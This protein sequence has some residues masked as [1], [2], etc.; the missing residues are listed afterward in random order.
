MTAR[1]IVD[2][3]LQQVIERLRDW[4][5]PAWLVGGTVRDDVLGR[6][7][8]DIDLVVPNGGLR[9]ARALADAL[10]A[11]YFPLDS[12][13]D[14]GRVVVRLA[15]GDSFVID[16]ARLR[17]P[18]LEAD[19]L[20]RD[21]SLNAMAQDVHDPELAIIDPVGGMA[22]LL[23]R[24]LRVA[25]ER[26]FVDD[27][28]RIVRGVRFAHQLQLTWEPASAT[29]AR[30]A[31]PTLHTVA[32]ER[33]R[34][35]LARLMGTATASQGLRAL[36]Q[37]DALVVLL[38]E[39]KALQGVT[40][41]PPH[42]Y[43][44]YDHTLRAVDWMHTLLSYVTARSD[45]V[46]VEAT[47]ADDEL[48]AAARSGFD[49][50]LVPYAADLVDYLEMPAE[51][52][53]QRRDLL[54]WAALLHDVGKPST[55]RTLPDGSI[56][57]EGHEATGASLAR[58]VMA[59]LRFSSEAVQRVTR[60]CAHHSRP[61]ALAQA[62]TGT[63]A[64]RDVYRYFQATHPTGV[65]TALLSLADHLAAWGPNLRAERYLRRVRLA[66]HL[67]DAYFRQYGELVA[68]MPLLDGTFLQ[69]TLG[70]QPGPL[71]G[72][73]LAALREEQAAGTVTTPEQAL[74]FTQRFLHTTQ[75]PTK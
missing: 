50:A 25:S 18:T 34:E 72:A 70:L 40:Q 67:L 42:V 66:A 54:P 63:P 11:A 16:V 46:A 31:A 24:Q 69:K 10:G 53:Y 8:H 45:G 15:D 41:Q 5:T 13:R 56:S 17:G 20:A 14:V 6:P 2:T 48:V 74:S 73:C 9:L 52:G 36:D 49:E 30:S 61:R 23:H 27:P 58:G 26:A 43:D 55:H 44:V 38:P 22:D 57:F 3:I 47:A 33:V 1:Q 64:R 75:P 28:L 32:G 21:F 35:E 65:E 51:Q 37:V 62:S 59:R 71:I 29:L 19:L 60:I 39:V 68:P 7:V 4:Q 12:T